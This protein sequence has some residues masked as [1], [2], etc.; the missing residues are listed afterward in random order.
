MENNNTFLHSSRSGVVVAH[1]WS[2]RRVR[3]C[4]APIYF[5]TRKTPHRCPL[6]WGVYL[7]T[8]SSSDYSGSNVGDQGIIN[9]EKMCKEVVVV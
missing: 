1:Y 6:R 3:L 7:T 2:D 8:V 5:H 4:A 9:L